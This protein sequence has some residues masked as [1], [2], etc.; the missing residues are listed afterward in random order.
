MA[1]GASCL[2]SW[3]PVHHSDAGVHAGEHIGMAAA[4]PASAELVQVGFH[5]AIG[6]TAAIAADDLYPESEHLSW[7]SAQ[8]PLVLKA[9]RQNAGGCEQEN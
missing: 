8:C 3:G 9:P 4:L 7:G 5:R 1:P 6:V 2:A